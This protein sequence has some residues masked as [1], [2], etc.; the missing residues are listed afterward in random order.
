MCLKSCLLFDYIS[1]YIIS[2]G[3]RLRCDEVWWCPSGISWIPLCWQV[4]PPQQAH[5]HTQ[6]VSQLRVHH[7]HLYTRGHSGN[8]PNTHT[9]ACVFPTAGVVQVP[10]KQTY[11]RTCYR[12][13]RY[14]PNTHTRACSLVPRPIFL[15]VVYS[16]Q[17]GSFRYPQTPTLE[18]AVY[19]SQQRSFRYPQTP[20]LEPAV[21]SPQQGSFRY[22]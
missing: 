5:L 2:L 21:Y 9:R 17:Q 15:S 7:P 19:S 22:P 8:P 20:T 4:Y 12:S 11:T 1:T 18:P 10:P 13:F 6:R 14:P 3:R 16:P